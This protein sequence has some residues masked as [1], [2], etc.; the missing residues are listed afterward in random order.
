ML[1]FSS[2][3]QLES[4][5]YHCG[6]GPPLGLLR[7][8]ALTFHST[9]LFFLP[10]Q[11]YKIKHDCRPEIHT[12]F[13]GVLFSNTHVVLVLPFL[14]DYLEIA[15]AGVVPHVFDTL[16]YTPIQWC[17]MLTGFKNATLTS[18]FILQKSFKCK[19]SLLR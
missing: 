4:Y 1:L 15:T 14:S 11:R 3:Y 18:C 6:R 9:K 8:G 17:Y 13:N 12:I 16:V 19:L 5:E 10:P 2:L 7:V